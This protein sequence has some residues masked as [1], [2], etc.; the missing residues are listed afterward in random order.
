VFTKT[1]NLTDNYHLAKAT[2]LFKLETTCRVIQSV[3]KVHKQGCILSVGNQT[4]NF[5][6]NGN[7]TAVIGKNLIVKMTKIK[8][9]CHGTFQC[10]RA[11][12]INHLYMKLILLLLLPNNPV[13]TLWI[14]VK[15]N[16]I[17]NLTHKLILET[18]SFPVWK[19]FCYLL[20]CSLTCFDHFCR[21]RAG[22][23]VNI[24]YSVCKGADSSLVAKATNAVLL[25]YSSD[26]LIH[27]TCCF[28]LKWV[29]CLCSVI[30][31]S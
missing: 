16:G 23:F 29:C 5:P 19:N 24:R 18:C 3:G 13:F 31:V 1:S 7:H 6:R 10:S 17:T 20:R 12:Q 28:K 11:L 25:T 14:S 8:W 2:D 9:S 26:A 4:L 27:T 15:I 21:Q 30:I 22:N